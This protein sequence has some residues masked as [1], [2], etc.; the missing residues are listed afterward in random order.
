MSDQAA[1]GTATEET[2]AEKTAK[3]STPTRTTLRVVL[4]LVLIVA[5]FYYLLKDIS[6][7]DVWAAITAMTWSELAGLALVADWNLCTDI[8]EADLVRIERKPQRGRGGAGPAGGH[9]TWAVLDHLRLWRGSLHLRECTGMEPREPGESCGCRQHCSRQNSYCG[10]ATG[11]FRGGPPPIK[12]AA[13]PL[14]LCAPQKLPWIRARRHLQGVR[15]AAAKRM[16]SGRGNRPIQACKREVR[17]SAGVARS[18]QT[19]GRVISGRS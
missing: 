4:A 14:A 9:E 3:K 6:L 1:E 7:A 18:Q 10:H 12:Q 17:W 8:G 19:V 2:A 5:I 15:S 11:S 16:S 13:C